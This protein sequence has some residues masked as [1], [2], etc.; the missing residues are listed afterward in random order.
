MTPAQFPNF[1]RCGTTPWD[2]HWR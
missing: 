1:H 2:R